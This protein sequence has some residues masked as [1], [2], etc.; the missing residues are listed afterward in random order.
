MKQGFHTWNITHQKLAPQ[1]LHA[2][3][4]SLVS[5][6]WT[7]AQTFLTNE[8]ENEPLACD[9]NVFGRLNL[10]SRWKITQA[11]PTNMVFQWQKAFQQFLVECKAGAR[12]SLAF[13]RHPFFSD[14][15]LSLAARLI[16]AS[17][18]T[19][20]MRTSNMFDCTSRILIR[21]RW[22]L[23]LVTTRNELFGTSCPTSHQ[24][25]TIER[26]I[27]CTSKRFSVVVKHLPIDR[28]D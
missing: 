1:K 5:S 10:Y 6:S 19:V 13:R 14:I 11:R 21:R 27:C 2:A 26:R 25:V 15:F 7:V 4:N 9:R 12:T 24:A 28:S 17:S 16:I 3:A 20:F 8:G 23:P 18:G 22:A